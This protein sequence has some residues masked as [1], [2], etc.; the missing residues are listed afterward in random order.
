MGNTLIDEKDEKPWMP[1]LEYLRHTDTQF[2]GFC[3]W[4]ENT[5]LFNAIKTDPNSTEIIGHSP[6]GDV[7]LRI[8]LDKT[9]PVNS[10][11]DLP[12]EILLNFYINSPWFT[13]PN[14]INLKKLLTNEH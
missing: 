6:E 7:N 9:K 1:Y 12:K 13:Q 4:V 5:M 11:T 8:F 2:A 10:A 14:N 3:S